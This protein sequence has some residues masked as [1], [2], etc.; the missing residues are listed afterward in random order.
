M[1]TIDRYLG[2][3]FFI[4]LNII[5]I[6]L[7]QT[8][9]GGTYFFTTGLIHIIAIG[10]VALAL[11]R[12][13]F[14]YYTYDPI[15]EKFI[16]ASLV[17]MGIFAVSHIVEFFSFE[18]LHR[19]EDAV[20]INVA[21]FYLISLL[22]IA[23]GTESFLRVLYEHSA[24]T[25]RVLIFCIICVSLLVPALL[26]NDT[27][28]SLDTDSIVPLLYTVAILATIGFNLYKMYQIKEGV[29]FMPGFINY[30]TVSIIFIGVAALTNVYYEFFIDKF[31]LPEYQALYF[32]HYAFYVALSLFF[33][34]FGKVSHLGGMLEEVKNM[35]SRGSK[36]AAPV[37]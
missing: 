17:A 6:V 19:F 3:N 8:I 36:P 21:N 33:L 2:L 22:V 37:N 23:V 25:T 20:Y 34:A 14:H 31:G 28:I 35:D 18:I 5:L 9:G 1:Q 32:S 13:F 7:A 29:K 27:L 24:R 30:L 10:F 4:V 26:L 12:V 15:L 16:H 11:L